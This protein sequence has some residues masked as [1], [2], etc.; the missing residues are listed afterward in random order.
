MLNVAERAE[1]A[2]GVKIIPIVVLAPGAT[3][4]G[5][6]PAVKAKSPALV[7]EIS[8]LEITRFAVPGLLTVRVVV[9][10]E[11]LTAW[12]PKLTEVGVMEK[13]ATVPVPDR[14]TVCGLP[15]T[16]SVMLRVAERAPA[17]PGVNAT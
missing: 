1:A 11:L 10:L 3:V 8:T 6:A 14:G 13:P 9:A 7:P 17:A 15:L 16:L 4:I 5:R 2:L 12:L